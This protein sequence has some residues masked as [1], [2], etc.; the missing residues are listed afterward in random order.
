MKRFVVI[1]CTMSALSACSIDPYTGE[2]KISNTGMGAGIGM[3]VGAASGAAIGAIAGGGEGAAIGAGI[4]AAA[5]A[6]VGGGIG[7]HMD[8]QEKI[9]RQRLEGTGVRVKRQGE[10][11]QL[12]MPG[13][14]TFAS[15]SPEINTAFYPTLD[16]VAIVLKEFDDTLINISGHTDSTG[17]FERNQILS[18]ERADSVAG[19]LVQSGI[20]AARLQARGFADRYPIAS[21]ASRSG[22]ATNRR[23]EISIRPRY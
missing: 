16:S 17:S 15:D 12:I 9:L 21:N 6:A 7:Y 14:I 3:G 1:F 20:N 13:N 19:Y 10:N 5:G 8:R 2:E 4:G 18:E 11:I 23:V 22:R